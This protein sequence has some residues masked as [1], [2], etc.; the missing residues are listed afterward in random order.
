MN[1]EEAL[2]QRIQQLEA[3]LDRI[4]RWFGEFPP[5]GD[6]WPSGEPVSYGAAYGS[7]GERDYMR[8]I[9]RAALAGAP[10]DPGSGGC[11]S[12]EL[13]RIDPVHPEFFD[14]L[15]KVDPEPIP[16]EWGGPPD[17]G[18][19]D[20]D[21]SEVLDAAPP[22]T[23]ALVDLMQRPSVLDAISTA[24]ATG[25]EGALRWALMDAITWH[26]AERSNEP[27]DSPRVDL[28]RAALEAPADPASVPP[29]RR[30]ADE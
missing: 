15:A 8:G 16:A 21:L 6:T 19:D 14:A 9:A 4:A 3:A 25:R 22:P 30:A 23:P 26:E 27:G 13:Q 12:E 28:W 7:N 1:T 24:P 2:R 18:S 5:T 20:R 29:E 17:P 10:A 11:T